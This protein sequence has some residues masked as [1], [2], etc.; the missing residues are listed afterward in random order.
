MGLGIIGGTFDPIHLGHLAIA[1]AAMAEAGLADMLFL[2]D[3]DPPHKQPGASGQHRLQMVR[4]A[5][6]DIPGFCVSD[7]E[8]TRQGTTYTVDTLLQ[9]QDSYPG[10][11]L[12][13][14]I[15]SDTLLVFD[16]WK[17][18][19]KVAS[20]CRML[21]APRPGQDLEEI[22]WHQRRLYAQLGLVSQLLSTPGPDISSSRIRQLI[23]AGQSIDHLVPGPVAAYIREERLYLT[24]NQGA[25]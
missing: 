13:Y 12:H 9:L 11:E 19:W 4:L 25:R 16:T 7:M 20:L 21:V 2:P 14:V 23:A 5:I 15:G 1:K 17:T 18:A 24:S 3:G 8:L 22:R 10:R 6:A